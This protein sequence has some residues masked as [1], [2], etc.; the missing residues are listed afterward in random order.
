MDEIREITC[1]LIYSLLTLLSTMYRA[2]H[3]PDRSSKVLNRI[4]LKLIPMKYD[5]S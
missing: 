3:F 1:S 2:E 4:V 5:T